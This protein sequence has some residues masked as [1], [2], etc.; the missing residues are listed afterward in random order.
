MPIQLTHSRRGLYSINEYETFRGKFKDLNNNLIPISEAYEPIVYM[1]CMTNSHQFPYRP[2]DGNIYIPYSEFI[3][4]DLKQY[5]LKC[6][7]CET[8]SLIFKFCKLEDQPRTF[9]DL[10]HKH[11]K[12]HRDVIDH[13]LSI[14]Y[15]KDDFF[16]IARPY[17]EDYFPDDH[18]NNKDPF[19]EHQVIHKTTSGFFSANTPITEAIAKQNSIPIDDIYDESGHY[20]NKQKGADMPEFP[21]VPASVG[22]YLKIRQNYDFYRAILYIITQRYIIV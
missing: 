7:K 22:K 4:K 17:Y 12:E 21:A 20:I 3:V 8:E 14:Y 9:N 6:P 19:A 16:G 11:I 18:T 1:K 5:P 13:P 2:E 15:Q 10:N